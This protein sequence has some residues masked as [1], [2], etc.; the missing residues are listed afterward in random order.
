MPRPF[1]PVVNCA[2][3]E[4]IFSWNGEVCE[5]IFHVS[6][7]SPFS[8][9]DLVAL[10]SVVNTWDSGNYTAYRSPAAV[11]TRIRTK[12]LDTASSPMEDYAL[13]TPRAGTQIGTALPNNVSYCLKL[14]TGLAGR[15]YRGRWFLVGLTST[16]YG[17]DTNHVAA[18]VSANLVA[19]LTNLKTALTAGGY[20]LGVVS[21][22]ASHAWRA[23]GV[24]TAATGFVAVDLAIDS[25]RRRLAGRGR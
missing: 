15:S 24:F 1:I 4:L 21:Y 19:M 3:V 14:S 10:R 6:K 18:A 16:Y 5:N 7:G 25:M 20:T 2:S 8:A 11:L 9:A 13:P 17:A 22:R 12:A 23:A